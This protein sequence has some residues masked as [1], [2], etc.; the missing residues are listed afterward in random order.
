MTGARLSGR[1]VPGPKGPL[2]VLLR[3]PRAASRGCVLVVPPFAEEMNKCRRMV[4]ELAVQL[5][6]R[7][8]ATVV[9]DL[10]GTG[11]SAGDFEDAD[12]E[13]WIGD[14]GAVASWA[15]DGGHRLT[16]C[17]AIRL[18]AALALDAASAGQL[19]AVERTVLWQPVFD[20]GRYLQQFL[21]LRI[22]AAMMEDRR[23]TLADLKARLT[24]GQT[25]EVA[26]YGLSSRLAAGLEGVDPQA[27]WPAGWGRVEWIEVVREAAAALPEPTQRLLASARERGGQVEAHGVVGE[28]YWSAT[29]VVV[30]SEVVSAALRHLQAESGA[31][32]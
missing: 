11:D 26:G 10:Y 21:R 19:P 22:A 17:L 8:I 15:R 18:G 27:P 28:P 5:A 23:E 14:L 3:E 20:G 25:V 24:A 1:F 12:W 32:A 16:G 7:G 30:N 29:E 13:T 4:T 9:P 2:F 6:E 31:T